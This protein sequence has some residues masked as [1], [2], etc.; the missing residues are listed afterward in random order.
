MSTIQI[1]NKW[2]PLP[3][4]NLVSSNPIKKG[5]ILEQN[6][7]KNPDTRESNMENSKIKTKEIRTSSALGSWKEIQG[8]AWLFLDEEDY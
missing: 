1:Q 8:L 2:Q 6:T 4:K 7:K 3:S 5:N